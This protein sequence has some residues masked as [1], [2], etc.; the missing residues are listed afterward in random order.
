MVNN[1]DLCSYLSTTN[2]IIRCVGH[3]WAQYPLTACKGTAFILNISGLWRI[4]A[5]M[6]KLFNYNGRFVGI[7]KLDRHDVLRFLSSGAQRYA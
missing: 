3:E 4:N 6:L 1:L 7:I 5:G 2:N